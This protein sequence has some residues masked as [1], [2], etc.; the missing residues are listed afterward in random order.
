MDVSP[1][2]SYDAQTAALILLG[3]HVHQNNVRRAITGDPGTASQLA[4]RF[5]AEILWRASLDAR[6]ASEVAAIL[7]E[8]P[9]SQVSAF[10]QR[11]RA[12]L[13]EA[14]LD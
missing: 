3:A 12:H 1:F 10:T 14:A 6:Y 4:A 8:S 7:A 13:P 2:T 9:D 5:E 11:L